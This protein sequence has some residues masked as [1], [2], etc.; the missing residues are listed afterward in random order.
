MSN[1]YFHHETISKC[2][3]TYAIY[4]HLDIHTHTHTHIHIYT[5]THIQ[6][7][8]TL[9]ATKTGRC[10]N[11]VSGS[12]GAPRRVLRMDSPVNLEHNLRQPTG[13]HPQYGPSKH[14]TSEFGTITHNTN[15]GE[16]NAHSIGGNTAQQTESHS[17][18]ERCKP[19]LTWDEM[20]GRL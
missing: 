19:K 1:R 5:Y 4:I 3:S 8:Q 2:R 11:P 13:A 15:K 20:A 16:E 6:N 17:K 14:N 9:N 12:Y 10:A 18:P 7:A